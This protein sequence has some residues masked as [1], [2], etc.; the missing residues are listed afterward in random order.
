MVQVGA[1]SFNATLVG[2]DVALVYPT[3]HWQVYPLPAVPFTQRAFAPQDGFKAHVGAQSAPTVA[4][5]E[6]LA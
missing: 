2:V 4:F 1:Q 3:E 5:A 6:A